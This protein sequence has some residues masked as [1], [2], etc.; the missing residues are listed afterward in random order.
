MGTAVGLF[1]LSITI[2][3]QLAV[4]SRLPLLNGTADIVLLSLIVWAL[5]ENVKIWEIRFWT[6]FAAIFIGFISAVPFIAVAIPYVLIMLM[7]RWLQ[8][9]IWKAS[10]W[11]LL[12]S[13]VLGTLFQQT[14]ILFVLRIINNVP[15]PISESYIFVILPSMVL[16]LLF[17]VPIYLLIKDMAEWLYPVEVE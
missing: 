13:V 14:V 1:Y 2:M 15:L 9:R 16:N 12:I 4:F 10:I 11:A 5:Q 6:L 7:I 8:Q 17:A 3:L